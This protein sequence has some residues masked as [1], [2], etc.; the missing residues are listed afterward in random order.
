[1]L[2]ESPLLTVLVYVSLGLVVLWTVRLARVKRRNP[3][4]WGGIALVLI[5]VAETMV[6][7][8]PSIIGMAPMVALLF[9]KPVPTAAPE[10]TPETV[11]CPKCHAYHAAGHSYCVNCGWELRRPYVED[12]Q[13][14]GETMR[15]AAVESPPREPTAAAEAPQPEVSPISVAEEPVE[16]ERETWAPPVAE[17]ATEPEAP[18]ASAS[19]EAAAVG[20]ADGEPG[21]EREPAAADA[22]ADESAGA[23]ETERYD[24]D[25]PAVEDASEPGR[26]GF[27]SMPTFRQALTPALFT[28]RGTEY[29]GEGR[30]QEA[31]DQFTKAIALD[32][33]YRAALEG[34]REA[35]LQLGLEAKAAE[36]QEL[37]N[38]LAEDP[39]A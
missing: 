28:G 13:V 25:A 24:P 1:M 16:E 21:S 23:G 4:V 27:D 12:P 35:Y 39:Q 38:S 6:P 22:V 7:D 3:L 32:G 5:V 9:L 20:P 15:S 36:D 2:A 10:P 33:Q 26:V 30:F 17:P 14:S 11:T 18:K 31:V 34:R 8:V 29:S 37:L 19:E